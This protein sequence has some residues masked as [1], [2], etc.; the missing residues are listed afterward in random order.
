[1]GGDGAVEAEGR[2]QVGILGAGG[3]TEQGE[4]QARDQSA[5]VTLGVSSL[6]GWTS[7]GR[8]AAQWR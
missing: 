6:V 7:T 1:M 8:S 3:L 4:L 2:A 5:G